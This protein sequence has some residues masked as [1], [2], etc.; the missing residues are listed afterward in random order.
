M[1]YSLW[2]VELEN[3]ESGDEI[4]K[5]AETLL[6]LK[7]N[8]KLRA[9]VNKERVFSYILIKDLHPNVF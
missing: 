4:S 1:N 3:Y 8:V 5:L 2:F 6:H 7:E 9:S